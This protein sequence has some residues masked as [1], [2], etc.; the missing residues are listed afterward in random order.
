MT[1]PETRFVRGTRTL[2]KINAE[3]SAQIT[4]ALAD[5]APDFATMLVEFPF[6]DL[7]SR[8]ELDLKAREIATIAAL[9][10]MGNA[11][12]QLKMHIKAGLNVGLKRQ[13]IVEIMMQMAV[14]GGFPSA[15]NAL[16]AARAVFAEETANAT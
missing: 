16:L 1:Q 9:T 13:Q 10:V 11:E 3:A 7:Y 6:G 5:I 14:Y 12:P 2:S 4:E 8:P 15:L